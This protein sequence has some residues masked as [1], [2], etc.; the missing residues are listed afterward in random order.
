MIIKS[1]YRGQLQPV[2]FILYS[3]L[4]TDNMKLAYGIR[5]LNYE[6][7]KTRNEIVTIEFG[8]AI[9]PELVKKVFR[10]LKVENQ[11][12]LKGFLLQDLKLFEEIYTSWT[13]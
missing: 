9:D 10:F 2:N 11:P 8:I 3:A 6:I 1:T 13:K 4:E 12:G 7:I 5:A